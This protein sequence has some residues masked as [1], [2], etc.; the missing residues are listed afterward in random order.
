MLESYGGDDSGPVKIGDKVSGTVVTVSDTSVFVNIGSKVDGIAE[1]EEFLGEDGEPTV[2]EGDTIELYAVEVTPGMIKLSKAL[3]GQGGLDQLEDAYKAGLP[4]EGKVTSSRKGGFDVQVFGRRT[5]CPVSQIDAVYVEDP[6]KYVGETFTFEIIKFEENG[7]NIVLSRRKMLE[8]ERAEQQE[9]FLEE[10]QVG[11]VMEGTVTKLMNFGAFVELT[12]GLE[13]MVHVSE[14]SWSRV[15]DP[16]DA[17]SPGDKV[18]VKIL[19]IEDRPKGG[20]KISL[21]MKQVE[22]DP[23]NSAEG[24]FKEGEKITGK[25]TRFAP[26]GAFVE[27]APGIEGLVHLSEISYTKRVIKAEDELTPGQEVSVL[28]KE[29]DPVKRRVGLSIRDA[30]G[31]PWMDVAEKYK[32]GSKVTGKVEKRENFGIFINLEPGI[33]GLLPKS[34]I[35]KSENPRAF[36][37]L[38]PED[39]VTVSVEAVKP[40]ERKITLAP[41]DKKEAEDW[42]QFAPKKDDTG[43][44]GM[45]LLGEKLQAAMAKKN[46]K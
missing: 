27:I 35:A 38:K 31:D 25:V 5:F 15:E 43:G 10:M 20:K 17:V 2:K 34:N 28:I 40:G 1:R 9:Q 33:T 18:T 23:W 3:S 14:L 37:D 46:K 19:G 16:A 24:K 7:R 4:V 42:K 11:S 45:G 8:K 13:G 44:G 29:F 22:G 32:A 12:P 41:A 26:F 30:E 6:E 36:D 39:E 21:S